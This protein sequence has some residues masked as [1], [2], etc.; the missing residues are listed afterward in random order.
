MPARR[1][2]RQAA[3]EREANSGASGGD[4][5]VASA[6]KLWRE[7]DRRQAEPMA[8]LAAQ[9]C[10][11]IGEESVGLR[12]R[13]DFG[14]GH[15]ANANSGEPTSHVTLEVEQ[16]MTGLGRRYEEDRVA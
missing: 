16:E 12:C 10:A 1:C 6:T 13:V 9:A 2:R 3:G 5:I 7:G 15:G 11:T 8:Q 4:L 14:I